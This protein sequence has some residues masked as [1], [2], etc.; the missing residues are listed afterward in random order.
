M[1]TCEIL[2]HDAL[3]AHS[4]PSLGYLLNDVEALVPAE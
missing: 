4:H 3:F 1:A 2:Y